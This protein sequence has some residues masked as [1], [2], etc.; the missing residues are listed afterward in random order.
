MTT[1]APLDVGQQAPDITLTD[2]TGATISLRA[3]TGKRV[4]L[5]FYPKDDTPGCTAQ[6]CSLRDSWSQFSAVDDV[7]I[8]GVS[9]Q[10]A[11]SHVKFRAKHDLP[12]QLL[13]DDEHELA[14]AFGFW[15]EKS[16]YGKKYFGMERST[17]VIGADGMIQA[18]VRKVKPADH[19]AW[20][21]AQLDIT[22]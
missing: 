12:F 3:L 2:D 7:V 1:T 16:M 21:A 20:L 18:I 14:N 10:D 5:Y 17:V 9:P 22:V 19:T 6:A 4:G 11:A 8:Y 13:V 15:V